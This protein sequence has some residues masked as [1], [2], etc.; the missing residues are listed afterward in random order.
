[1]FSRLMYVNM[2]TFSAPYPHANSEPAPSAASAILCAVS[3]Q[4]KQAMLMKRATHA[5]ITL[6]N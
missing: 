3:H 5:C 2:I 1:M 4:Y 6:S